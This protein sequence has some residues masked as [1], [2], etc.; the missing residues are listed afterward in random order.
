MTESRIVDTGWLSRHLADPATVVIEV[1]HESST[2]GHA[3]TVPGSRSV[4]WKSLLWHSD[5]REFA[6]GADLAARLL[7]LGAGASST[8]VF[9]GRPTQFAAYAL[10]V[11]TAQGLGGDLR[12]LDGGVEAWL[13]DSAPS[14][15]TPSDVVEPVAPLPVIPA[16]RDDVLVGRDDV[17]AA[18]G[19]ATTVVDLRTAEEFSGSR[20]SPDT[21][22]VDHG[23]ERGGHIPGATHLYFRE[24]LDDVGRIRP[25]PELRSRT[26]DLQDASELI[27]YCRLSHRAALGWLIFEDVLN[28]PRARVYDGSW[29]EWGSLVG[30]PIER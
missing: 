27:F 23:A 7:E 2:H 28:D 30:A 20:V 16:Y 17:A 21:E 9:V 5:R 14:I 24:L 19:T 3:G 4:Y 26:A 22:P 13:A 18:L 29:T 25:E 8:V 6:T 12:Y 1:A 15:E 10:W 11:A